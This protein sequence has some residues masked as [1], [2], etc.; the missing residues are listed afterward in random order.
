MFK[1]IA[2]IA[3]LFKTFMHDMMA[4]GEYL[5]TGKFVVDS[6]VQAELFS[7]VPKVEDA[8]RRLLAESGLAPKTG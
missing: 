8:A 2:K 5:E 3:G 4:M 1:L 7:P 6:K